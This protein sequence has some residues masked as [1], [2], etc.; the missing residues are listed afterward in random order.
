MVEDGRARLHLQNLRRADVIQTLQLLSE[1][2][3]AVRRVALGWRHGVGVLVRARDH[4]EGAILEGSVIEGDPAGDERRRLRP[5]VVVVLAV[6]QT[7]KSVSAAQMWA[8]RF[9]ESEGKE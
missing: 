9:P 3:A 5:P 4:V 6:V 2:R 7:W 8:V 1:I